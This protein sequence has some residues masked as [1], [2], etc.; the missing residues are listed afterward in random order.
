MNKAYITVQVI[1]NLSVQSHNMSRANGKVKL[2]K[3]LG[4]LYKS[5]PGV[6]APES[7]KVVRALL[8]DTAHQ[9]LCYLSSIQYI[10]GAIL[11]SAQ[12]MVLPNT[13]VN[14]LGLK[15]NVTKL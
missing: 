10:F 3:Y 8:S 5:G 2:H 6:L 13:T 1:Y 12:T 4:P 15:P 9:F 7:L 14:K 11:K